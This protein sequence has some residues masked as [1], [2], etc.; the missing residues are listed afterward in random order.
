[1][2]SSPKIEKPTPPAPAPTQADASVRG[3]GQRVAGQNIGYSSLISTSASGLKR[4]ADTAKRSL[5]GGA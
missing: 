2:F 1:M 5:I 4:K 3:A